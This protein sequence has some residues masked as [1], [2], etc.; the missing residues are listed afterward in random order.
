MA[1]PVVEWTVDSLAPG[2]DI[3]FN[4][5]VLGLEDAAIAENPAAFFSSLP[6]PVAL[7]AIS[8]SE[9]DLCANKNCDDSSPC[10]RDYCSNGKC[11]HSSLNDVSCGAGKICKSGQ[12]TEMPAEGPLQAADVCQVAGMAFLGADC[13]LYAII[14]AAVVIA[15]IAILAFLFSKRKRAN[16]FGP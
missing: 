9:P 14:M 16:P 4:Y 12:C 15:I 10:T 6:A 13:A 7:L 3:N 5:S 1:D 8:A 2:Q 11:I